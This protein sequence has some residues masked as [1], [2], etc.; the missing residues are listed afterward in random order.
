MSTLDATKYLIIIDGKEKTD[1]LMFCNSTPLGIAVKFENGYDTY[2]YKDTN[3]IHYYEAKGEPDPQLLSISKNGKKFFGIER[4]IDFGSYLRIY[5]EG[6]S[7]RLYKTCELHI[8]ASGIAP[9]DARKRF[10]Y[11]KELSKIVGITTDEG[12]K[13][14]FDRFE[15]MGF[16]EPDAILSSYLNPQSFM[17]SLDNTESV[18]FPFGFNR[19]QKSAVEK[20][21]QNKVSIIEGPPGTGKTQTILNIIAN[22]IMQ[23]KTVA[24]VSNNNSATSNV[25]EKLQKYGL[26]FIAAFL[27]KDENKN[28]FIEE[29][30]GEYPEI[31]DWCIEDVEHENIK[32]K[33]RE[34]C[35]EL[36][37]KL[38]FQTDLAEKQLELSFLTIEKQ[39]FD[40][41]LSET[42]HSEVDYPPL[43]KF[44]SNQIYSLW[45]E[46][47]HEIDMRERI[48]KIFKIKTALKYR[49]FKKGFYDNSLEDQIIDF[50]KRFYDVRIK[51]LTN[52][53]V[54]LKSHLE[55]YE[56]EEKMKNLSEYSILLFKAYLYNRFGSS[57]ERAVFAKKSLRERSAD[58]LGEYPLILSTTH[59]LRSCLSQE[60]VFDYLIIDE[61]SQVDI[62]S[63]SLALSCAKNVVVVGDLKQLPNVVTS[64]IAEQINPV[65]GN[66]QPGDEYNYANHSLLSSFE[67]VFSN[68][69]RT[70][71][72][73]HY[74]CHPKIIHFCNQKFYNNELIVMTKDDDDKDVLKAFIT[75]GGNH[76]R[77]HY[78][79]RQIDVIKHEMLPQLECPSDEI[80]VISPYR[81]QKF[82]MQEQF[83]IEGMAIDTVHKFQG[84]E[85]NNIIL[86]TVDNVISE[87]VDNPNMLNVAVSRAKDRLFVVVSNDERNA[88]TNIDDLVRYIQYNNMEVVQSN[89]FSVFDL[90]YKGFTERRMHFI[91]KRISKY[92]S[93]NLMYQLIIQILLIE[94]FSKLGVES[95]YQLKNL[96]RD[97]DLLTNDERKYGMHGNTAVDFL[98]FDRAT[99][100]KPVL[101]I[102]V[103]GY[104]YHKKGSAQ[105]R[106]DIKKNSILDKHGIPYLRFSTVE[107]GEKDRLI[108]SLDEILFS[109]K[110]E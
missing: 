108:S 3:R 91:R 99:D 47:L 89:I 31:S 68:A 79:Q 74:R 64:Q 71:L 38:R 57:K 12:R 11:L 20:S 60:T 73:E 103:D 94:R 65:F 32:Q 58:F 100:K 80:G 88:N 5:F 93:E 17:N 18:L 106:R 69:P 53:I 21:F 45:I 86:T 70:L 37:E 101:V 49:F 52:E 16:V 59:S 78:N 85:K 4:I 43:N 50:Q 83:E 105:Y 34:L 22:I 46:L 41:Y 82:A 7:P 27:G 77:G 8:K 90:L 66:F 95:Q 61:A 107:S 62:V 35:A 72:R 44:N 19:S 39:Y 29:Q 51:E 67:S 13:I 1:K 55:R 2:T 36:S 97:T 25:V 10:N 110:F 23:E 40:D 63:G 109:S 28:K 84:R 98:I 96:I 54:G 9:V 92:E 33:V 30:T 6:T 56:F 76:A 48:T 102:E 81:D 24:V 14:L 104:K 15:K 42:E 75:A 87:F 26:S